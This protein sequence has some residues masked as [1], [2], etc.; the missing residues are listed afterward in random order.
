M[1]QITESKVWSKIEYGIK[2]QTNLE[3]ITVPGVMSNNFFWCK[4]RPFL[5]NKGILRNNGTFLIHNGRFIDDEKQVTET[6]NNTYI[7]IVEYTNVR[8]YSNID[9][10]SAIDQ[11]LQELSTNTNR[12]LVS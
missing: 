8:D 3:H 7:N 5:T 10:S 1:E 12:T 9:F 6:L 4:V 2:Y 11:Q